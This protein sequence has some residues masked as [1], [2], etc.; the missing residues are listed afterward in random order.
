MQWEVYVTLFFCR[1]NLSDTSLTIVRTIVAGQDRFRKKQ[2]K[3][4]FSFLTLVSPTGKYQQ[5]VKPFTK[6]S[7]L[8]QTEKHSCH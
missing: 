4:I 2:K 8:N 7:K 5:Q 3:N 6:N 1:A